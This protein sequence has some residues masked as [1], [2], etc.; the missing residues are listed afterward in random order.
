MWKGENKE[1]LRFELRP[2]G[3][4]GREGSLDIPICFPSLYTYFLIVYLFFLPPS[5]L[6]LHFSL[7][8]SFCFSLLFVIS[9]DFLA[10]YL[11]YFVPLH[12]SFPLRAPLPFSF[13]H[14]LLSHSPP[15]LCSYCV[16]HSSVFL[17]SPSSRSTSPFVFIFLLIYS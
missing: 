2:G 11:S 9:Y 14:F 10:I 16:S 3:M 17:H 12:F 15:D 7:C 13:F 8:F 6:P 4:D 1:G 5:I